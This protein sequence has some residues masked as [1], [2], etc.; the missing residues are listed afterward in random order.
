MLD[1][2]VKYAVLEVLIFCFVAMIVFIYNGLVGRKNE[3]ENALGGLD[4]QLK[5]RFDLV[6]NLISSVKSYMQH[7]ESVLRA[8]VDLRNQSL[9][10]HIPMDK[11]EEM[12]AQL[13]QLLSR[14]M[15]QVEQYPEL[16]ASGNFIELQKSLFEIEKNISASRRFYNAA[17]TDYNNALEMVP[18]NFVARL[19]GYQRKDVFNIPELER[20]NVDVAGLFN[21]KAS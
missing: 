19:L 21:E 15:V 4:S 7:E 9:R 8:I 18:S 11:K 10:Q 12:N 13:T 17:V 20:K 3:V 14:L 1:L 16:K 6:P 2:V 5:L